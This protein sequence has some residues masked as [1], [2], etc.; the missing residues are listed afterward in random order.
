MIENDGEHREAIKMDIVLANTSCRQP[1]SACEGVHASCS[2]V[3]RHV[4]RRA[5]REAPLLS[6]RTRLGCTKIGLQVIEHQLCS[7]GKAVLSMPI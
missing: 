6:R 7:A 3:R 4:E 5:R 1:S 2:Y